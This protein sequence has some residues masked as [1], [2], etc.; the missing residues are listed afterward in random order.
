MQA[1]SL[2]L[3][4]LRTH[5]TH[6]SLYI[7]REPTSVD[8]NTNRVKSSI[9]RIFYHIKEEFDRP[10]VIDDR[11]RHHFVNEVRTEDL[12][13]RS[14][15][16]SLTQPSPPLP[17]IMPNAPSLSDAEKEKLNL[18]REV[19]KR[20]SKAKVSIPETPPLMTTKH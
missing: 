15:I 18:A 10:D 6:H 19:E 20:T 16:T 8:T 5:R 12:V 3:L 14:L 17:Q 1:F 2:I 9:L 13:R 11:I 7:D 4:A